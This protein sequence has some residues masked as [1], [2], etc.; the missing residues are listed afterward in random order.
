MK[1]S[2]KRIINCKAYNCYKRMNKKKFNQT[3]DFWK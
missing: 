3:I 2:R 1:H